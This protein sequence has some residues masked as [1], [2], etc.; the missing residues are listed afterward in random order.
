MQTKSEQDFLLGMNP[1]LLRVDPRLLG[2]DPGLLGVDPGLSPPA[3][4][5]NSLSL[6]L[7]IHDAWHT[8]VPHSM[9]LAHRRVVVCVFSY[10]ETLFLHSMAA[11]CHG[12]GHAELAACLFFRRSKNFC[13]AL[14]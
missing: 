5:S 10:P 13:T 2:V 9:L 7:I 6:L 11:L 12:V 3:L 14:L 8:V 4:D 1:G